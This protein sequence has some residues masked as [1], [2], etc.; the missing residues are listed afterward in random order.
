ME[1]IVAKAY[2][3]IRNCRQNSRLRTPRDAATTIVA[4][5]TISIIGANNSKS[6]KWGSA[7][8]TYGE[9]AAFNPR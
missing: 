4:M 5:P 1:I 6:H 3:K 8:Q 2:P 7:T 9:V